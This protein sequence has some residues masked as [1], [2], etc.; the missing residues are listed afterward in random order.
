MVPEVKNRKQTSPSKIGSSKL[1]SSSNSKS[2]NVVKAGQVKKPRSSKG[3]K[4]EDEE[5]KLLRAIDA[6]P[7]IL[8]IRESSRWKAKEHASTKR[9]TQEELLLDPD[10]PTL[11]NPALDLENSDVDE[12]CTRTKEKDP[13]GGRKRGGDSSDDD[14]FMNSPERGDDWKFLSGNEVM[15][16]VDVSRLHSCPSR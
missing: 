8:L 5:E 7:D 15:K 16:I 12:D 2:N 14:D 11:N 4:S 9:K 6:I 13:K 3:E 1:S 10:D